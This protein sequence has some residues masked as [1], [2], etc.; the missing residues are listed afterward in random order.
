MF[1][2]VLAKLR[3]KMTPAFREATQKALK[4]PPPSFKIHNAFSTLGQYDYVIIYEAADEEEAVKMGVVWSEFCETQ[5][6]VAIPSEED[7][8]SSNR[9]PLFFLSRQLSKTTE[10]EHR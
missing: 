4:S 5:T 6:M 7:R 1:F 3:G 9:L 10:E 8:N 2:I